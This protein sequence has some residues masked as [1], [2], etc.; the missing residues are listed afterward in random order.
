MKFWP[1]VLGAWLILTGLNSLIKLNFQYEA[2][3]MGAL[4]FIAGVLVI[5]RK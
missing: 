5:V 1:L 4:A 2:M 3:V